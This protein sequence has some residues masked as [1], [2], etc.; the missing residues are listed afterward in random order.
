MITKTI[1]A[2][3]VALTAL[4][5]VPASAANLTVQFGNN[6]PGWGYH[7]DHRPHRVSTDQVRWMLRNQGYRA[8]RFV[9]SRGAVYQVRASKNGRDYFLVVSARTGEILQRH[10]V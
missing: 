8:I 3:L 2:G 6:G 4:S 7:N 10:R 5:A 9:D 1:A